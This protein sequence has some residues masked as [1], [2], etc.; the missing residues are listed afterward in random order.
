MTISYTAEY[1]EDDGNTV[2]TVKMH[3]T[4]DH[5]MRVRF[6]NLDG[7]TIMCFC[8]MWVGSYMVGDHRIYTPAL[9]WN[10][11]RDMDGIL[12]SFSDLWPI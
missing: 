1:D 12:K 10:Q 5:E 11:A 6:E 9:T 4:K 7:E 2:Y 3:P 8:T